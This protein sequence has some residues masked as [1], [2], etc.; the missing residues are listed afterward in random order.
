MSSLDNTYNNLNIVLTK[1]GGDDQ[2]LTL[3]T[4]VKVG[5]KIDYDKLTSVKQFQMNTD[6]I[7]YTS[8]STSFNTPL[9]RLCALKTA[10]SAVELPPDS[11]SLSLNKNIRLNYT[12]D[13]NVIMDE[14]S[15]NP[16]YPL[17]NPTSDFQTRITK[18]VSDNV[19]ICQLKEV[20][21]TKNITPP[22]SIVNN[23]T[24]SET[25]LGTYPISIVQNASTRAVFRDVNKII[26]AKDD[27]VTFTKIF[28]LQNFND[29]NFTQIDLTSLTTGSANYSSRISIIGIVQFIPVHYISATNCKFF[30]RLG[31]ASATNNLYI[32]TCDGDP[33]QL[34]SYSYSTNYLIT[35]ASAITNIPSA[36]RGTNDLAWTSLPA[37][38]NSAQISGQRVNIAYYDSSTDTFITHNS[39][40]ANTARL[41]AVVNSQ[42]TNALVFDNLV[43]SA[44]VGA[45]T[46]QM[47][48]SHGHPNSN[49]VG[50]AYTN[51]LATGFLKFQLQFYDSVNKKYI[52]SPYA[53]VISSIPNV[54]NVT[55]LT[56]DTYALPVGN[57]IYF[58]FI[59]L[60]NTDVNNRIINL[61]CYTWD[62][63]STNA[64]IFL[65]TTPIQNFGNISTASNTIYSLNMIYISIRVKSTNS[66][67]IFSS[68]AGP[69]GANADATMFL[70]EDNFVNTRIVPVPNICTGYPLFQQCE[71]D[72]TIQVNAVMATIY[73][74][75]ITTRGTSFNV[76]TSPLI[77]IKL[78]SV[79]APVLSPQKYLTLD[80]NITTGTTTQ[81]YS[82]PTTISASDI[83]FSSLPKCSIMPTTSTQ[84][85]N[86]AYVDSIPPPSSSLSSVL[87]VGN[88]AGTNNIDMNNQQIQN[89][90]QITS[91]GDLTLN[92]VGSINCNGKT[93]DLTNGR[94]HN[95]DHIEGPNNVDLDIEAKGTGDILFKTNI[96]TNP[97]LQIRDDGN[98]Y[99]SLAPYV[100][101]L[102]TVV[103]SA[104]C[105]PLQYISDNF[106]GLSSNQTITGNKT[107]NVLPS[108]SVVPVTDQ[109]FTNKKYITDNCVFLSGTQTITGNKTLSGIT[110]LGRNVEINQA[111]TGASV[112]SVDYNTS[113]G[114]I[115]Y[116]ASPV[117]SNFTVNVI[118]L[119][120]LTN[121]TYTFNFLINATTNKTYIGTFSVSS[122][123]TVGSA[124][125]LLT[126]GGSASI[127][128]S[129]AS[130]IL[131]TINVVY[132]GGSIVGTLNSVSQWY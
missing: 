116:I 14:A 51:N 110:T 75:H 15:N 5:V 47:P 129:S 99:F 98:S 130:R 91:T 13:N 55:Q 9:E 50:I 27:S 18:N 120:A 20:S 53:N 30:I 119:P 104:Q 64:P 92:P 44:G 77:D 60:N 17:S 132:S 12:S 122:T 42:L 57:L 32:I 82:Y 58:Y 35:S 36:N 70:T 84:L 114:G 96:S 85:V 108:S 16:I 39:A 25:T 86:K 93:I 2:T 131:Q 109:E 101:P 90:S 83:T 31:E 74:E 6:G 59:W 26:F 102:P 61:A 88:S 10:L 78:I 71:L 29:N 8:G 128:V 28:Y 24:V 68:F 80:H 95:C 3:N 89:L 66:I 72:A 115:Y 107:F 38:A 121:G 81:T 52:L 87:T 49:I 76:G 1:D 4:A 124:L 33:T 111:I 97:V 21:F 113:S 126:N 105:P 19:D 94:I 112:I 43:S 62:K 123:G 48:Y 65:S 22:T 63:T 106:V 54:T 100:S 117:S 56:A 37:I 79:N 73:P 34:S 45:T 69:T 11:N 41:T 46:T 67:E 127:T 118:N 125:T 23:L 103:T 7:T 40:T